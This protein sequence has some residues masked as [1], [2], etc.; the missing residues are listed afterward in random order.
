MYKLNELKVQ[1]QSGQGTGRHPA[2]AQ[3]NNRRRSQIICGAL[4]HERDPGLPLQSLIN[5]KTLFG[6]FPPLDQDHVTGSHT[7]VLPFIIFQ[8]ILHSPGMAV[9]CS[10]ALCPLDRAI[11]QSSTLLRT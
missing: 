5:S 6:Q 4:S 3:K 8:E 1:L 10:R 11:L 9:F 2:F 7:V